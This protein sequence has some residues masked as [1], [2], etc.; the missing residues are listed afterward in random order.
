MRGGKT[1]VFSR[2]SHEHCTI[3]P[4][5]LCFLIVGRSVV[6]GQLKKTDNRQTAQTGIERRGT[7]SGRSMNKEGRKARI[8][9]IGKES[10]H[11]LC[12]LASWLPGFLASL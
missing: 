8:R 1:L 3:D 4:R 12:F 10:I 5:G 2:V 9:R 6:R 11:H 7:Q